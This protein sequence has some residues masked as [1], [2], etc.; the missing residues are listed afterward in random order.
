MRA[1]RTC[2][3]LLAL[4]VALL[5]LGPARDALAAGF[6]RPN[7]VGAPAIGMGGAFAAIADDP[8]AIRHNPAGISLI[9]QTSFLLDVGLVIPDRQYQPPDCSVTGPDLE[10]CPA[11]ATTRRLER[12]MMTPTLMPALAFSTRFGKAHG[13]GASRLA[14]GFA[15]F[16]SQGGAIAFSDKLSRGDRKGMRKTQIALLEFVPAVAY[17]ASDFLAVGA[18]LRIGVGLFDLDATTIWDATAPHGKLI[19]APVKASTVGVTAGASLGVMVRPTRWLNLAFVYHTGMKV[20]ASGSLD[21]ELTP[22]IH[23]SLNVDLPFPQQL[24]VGAAFKPLDRLRLAVQLDWTNWASFQQLLLRYPPTPAAV[25]L[26][27]QDA[28]AGH[29][30]G[31]YLI[32]DSMVA[33]L[34]YAI[35]TNAI[36]DVSMERQYADG[37]KH[38]IGAGF[39]YAITKRFRLDAAFEY[40][41]SPTAR[42][43]PV[44]G[45]SVP[46]GLQNV[47]PGTYKGA[48]YQ[49]LLTGQFRY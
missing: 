45:A 13:E 6:G 21:I 10:A 31:E 5:A 11:G 40:L 3:R 28:W 19:D 46:S 15:S 16:L 43:V 33:R 39:G 35:E 8:S 18:G 42:E 27:F 14:L 32:G 23:K 48:V 26:N 20:P 49:A 34:G 36:P 12:E 9:P 41:F 24:T 7:I 1:D 38:T 22:A 29:V 37:L 4:G 25:Y 47:A 2:G 30:G 17:Q 44:S